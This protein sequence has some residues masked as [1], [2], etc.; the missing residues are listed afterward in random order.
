MDDYISREA[1]LDFHIQTYDLNISVQDERILGDRFE[2]F[3]K[4][5]SAADVV[6]R[7]CYDRIL[8]ENDTMRKQLAQ[9]GKKPGDKMDDVRPVVL[10]RDCVYYNT[11]GCADGFGWCEGVMVG[12]GTS[13]DFFCAEGKQKPYECG[14]DMSE[15]KN[16]Q[17][18]EGG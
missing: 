12:K 10:C 9:I 1:A 16:G 18:K 5:I 15:N 14:A 4:S 8:A 6:A 17:S 2:E 3:L 7:D 13:D 11:T